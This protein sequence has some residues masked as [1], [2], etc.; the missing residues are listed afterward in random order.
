MI[1]TCKSELRPKTNAS[2]PPHWATRW[3]R[4]RGLRMNGELINMKKENNPYPK[5]LTMIAASTVI[6]FMLMYL[7]T[8]AADHI[9]FCETRACI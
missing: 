5:F 8:Y 3:H 4:F 6:M 1:S 2:L 9:Y 7:N